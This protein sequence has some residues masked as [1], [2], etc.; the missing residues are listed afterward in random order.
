MLDPNLFQNQT[1]QSFLKFSLIDISNMSILILKSKIN[2][3]QILTP[4][5]TQIGP[6]IKNTQN[7]LKFGSFDISNILISILMSK[8]G[9]MKYIPAARPNYPKIKI[10][11]KFMFDISS[12]PILTARSDKSFIEHLQHIMPKFVSECE[13][14]S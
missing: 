7:S 6:R 8:M 10:A 5:C 2:F 11:L 9:F 13:F 1:A 14:Q 12:V 3:F 4:C